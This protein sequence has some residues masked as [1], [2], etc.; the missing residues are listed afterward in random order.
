MMSQYISLCRCD[1]LDDEVDDL[2]ESVVSVAIGQHT[3][4]TL[5][6]AL[7]LQN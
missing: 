6:F 5:F 1:S 4:N 7:K 2:G 3:I